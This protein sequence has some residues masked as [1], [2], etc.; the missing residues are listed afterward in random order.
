MMKM[1]LISVYGVHSLGSDKLMSFPI[2][3]AFVFDEKESTYEW[4]L[5]Q[6]K[7]VL[8]YN[9][10]EAPVFATDKCT[11]LMNALNT[12]FPDSKKTLCIWHMMNNVRDNILRSYSHLEYDKELCIKKIERMINAETLRDFEE[13]EDELMEL[14]LDPK[15]VTDYFEAIEQDMDKIKGTNKALAYYGNHI[16]PYKE[17]WAGYT[18]RFYTHFGCFVYLI[19]NLCT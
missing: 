4:F 9:A 19:L 13:L 7:S 2:A 18:T 5:M 11:A 16:I 6:L 3:Y 1:P 17:K 8:D 12:I 15:V 10:E 14:P